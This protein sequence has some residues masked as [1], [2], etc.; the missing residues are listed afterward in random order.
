[1][2]KK[3][4]STRKLMRWRSLQMGAGACKQVTS[5]DH[6]KPEMLRVTFG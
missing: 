6:I 2:R 1:M 3:G 4:K 5:S